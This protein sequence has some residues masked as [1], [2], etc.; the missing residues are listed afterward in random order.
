MMKCVL[1]DSSP[2]FV[3]CVACNGG[4]VRMRR[5]KWI[6]DVLRLPDL[7]FLVVF[8]IGGGMLFGGNINNPYSQFV[9]ITIIT[10]SCVILANDWLGC[11]K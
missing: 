4:I 11:E 1:S 6:K 9:I 3:G 2:E 5:I 7:L 8:A 10:I